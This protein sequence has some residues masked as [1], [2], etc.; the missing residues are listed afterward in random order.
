EQ[1]QQAAGRVGQ[2]GVIAARRKE[3]ESSRQYLL[4][5]VRIR[6]EMKQDFFFF[7]FLLD[8]AESFYQAGDH[9]RA[10]QI[11]AFIASQP[12]D[13]ETQVYLRT[14]LEALRAGMKPEVYAR[15][16][17]AGES[18]NLDALVQG[19]LAEYSHSKDP[20]AQGSPRQPASPTAYPALVEPLSPRELEVL[21]WIAAGLS[22]QEIAR[23]MVVTVGTVKKHINNIF[24]KMQVSSRTQAAARAR[25]LG[26]L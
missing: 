15:A 8:L 2:L 24:G 11:G 3:Y 14:R 20:A 6:Y 18:T 22:N 12:I 7:W 16:V 25:E 21:A 19:L 1:G 26:I 13:H 10:V 4:E 5:A 17:L 23:K 9:E